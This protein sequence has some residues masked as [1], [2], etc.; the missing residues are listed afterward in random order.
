MNAEGSEF[1]AAGHNFLIS[2]FIDFWRF[3]EVTIVF[4]LFHL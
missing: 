1:E 3:D 2:L 4:L